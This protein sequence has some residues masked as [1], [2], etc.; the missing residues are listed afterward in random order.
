MWDAA[1]YIVSAV[2]LALAVWA[3]IFEVRRH[4]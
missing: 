2:S 3:F 1:L 4:G